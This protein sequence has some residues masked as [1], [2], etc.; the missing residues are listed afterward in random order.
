MIEVKSYLECK[1]CGKIWDAE[2][3]INEEALIV[4]L[5]DGG[6]DFQ[7]LGGVVICSLCWDGW[8]KWRNERIEGLVQEYLSGGDIMRR[9]ASD[10]IGLSMRR[11]GLKL[12]L[13]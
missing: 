9:F 11:T 6:F 12:T 2:E 13:T 10:G 8:K 4:W 1:R 5:K 3:F 7:S